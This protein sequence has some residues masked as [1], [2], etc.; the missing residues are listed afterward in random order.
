MNN[1]IN[2]NTFKHHTFFIELYFE[3]LLENIFGIYIFIKYTYPH[4]NCYS[5]APVVGLYNTDM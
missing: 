5:N 1:T 4:G 3:I 2:T